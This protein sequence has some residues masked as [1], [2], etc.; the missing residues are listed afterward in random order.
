MKKEERGFN[1]IEILV[2][3][4]ILHEGQAIARGVCCVVFI[5][6]NS[7][8]KRR[9]TPDNVDVDDLRI[10]SKIEFRKRSFLN[11]FVKVF[12]GKD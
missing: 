3:F 12:D 10:T 11:F 2:W 4:F 7:Q 1:E 9:I 5:Y 6:L 8:I